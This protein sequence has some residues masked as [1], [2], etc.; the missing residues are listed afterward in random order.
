[1]GDYIKVT[2]KLSPFEPWVDVLSYELGGIKFETFE[3]NDPELMAYIQEDQYN[4][5]TVYNIIYDLSDSVKIEFTTQRIEQK[6]WNKIWE[7]NY[8]PIIVDEKLLIR[9][10]FHQPDPKIP[11]E[12]LL[13]PKMSFGTGHHATTQ[14][15]V[16][17][18]FDLEFENAE[19]FD[20]GCGTGI[21]SILAEKLKA[22]SVLAI[23]V[24][25]W[26]VENA[27][28]NGVI[29]KC[30][31]IIVEK[32]QIHEV[33]AN[34][35][36]IIL[37]NINLNVILDDLGTYVENLSDDG[38]LILSGFLQKDVGKVLDMASEIGL[39]QSAS[40][41]LNDWAMLHFMKVAVEQK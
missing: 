17:E 38:H 14:L 1:M 11:Y 5:Q 19:V 35:Y 21:L 27:K 7:E 40:N 25:D 15:M 2:F 41:E 34:S 22:K 6:N 3:Q 23:D 18:M 33:S 31:H 28:E 20:V 10:P 12:I 39:V 24:D 30:S 37:A 36:N 8:H 26:A 4:E 29:N 32:R 16:K 9:A 13:T